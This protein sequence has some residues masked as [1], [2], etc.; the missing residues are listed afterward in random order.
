MAARPNQSALPLAARQPSRCDS[1]PAE[2]LQPGDRITLDS[3]AAEVERVV[4]AHEAGVTRVRLV[5]E[6]AGRRLR[7]DVAGDTPMQLPR[8]T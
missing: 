6:A 5:V 7:I 3:G 2:Q 8:R 4:V 1:L